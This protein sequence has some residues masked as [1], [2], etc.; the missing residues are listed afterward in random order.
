MQIKTLVLTMY[1]DKTIK[2]NAAKLKGYFANAFKN[3][4]LLHQHKGDKLVY[5]YPRV[6]Y[7]II[8]NVPFIVSINEGTDVLKEIY[9]KYHSIKIGENIYEIV[10]KDIVIKE[11]DFG[12]NKN[13]FHYK[14]IIPW[15][16][17][18]QRNYE[19]FKGLNRSNRLT[20]LNKILIGNILSMSKS[21]G[22]VVSEEIKV[23]GTFKPVKTSLKGVKMI[24][25]LGEFSVNFVL[26]DYIG[27]GK[28]VS[29][30]F[31]TIVRIGRP[32]S[33]SY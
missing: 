18:N 24:G 30:G 4:I 16:A 29:R 9:N 27:L 10:E 8:R 2:G 19:K 26:P 11:T 25:F 5:R 6:Q 12:I 23:R 17:L 13:F 28:S 14:F 20:M 33:S 15:L 1:S 21:L 31:G 22:Y 3:Y 32:E 7:K